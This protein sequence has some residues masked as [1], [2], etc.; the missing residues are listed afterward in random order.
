[1]SLFSGPGNWMQLVT[2]MRGKLKKKPKDVGLFYL[3]DAVGLC[4][5]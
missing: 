2:F 5:S 1:L 3:N 4:T